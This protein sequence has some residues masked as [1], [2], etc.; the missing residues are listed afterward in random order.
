MVVGCLYSG[1]GSNFYGF[2]LVMTM[3]DSFGGDLRFGLP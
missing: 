2:D 1:L 3:G